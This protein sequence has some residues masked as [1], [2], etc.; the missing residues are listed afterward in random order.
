MRGSAHAGQ[1]GALV[2]IAHFSDCY[3]PRVNGVTTSIEV[4]K[5]ALEAA[6]HEV[7]LFT[8]GY[9]AGNPPE[10]G[11]VRFS[12]F[13][14]HFQ[15]EDRGILPWPPRS[16]KQWLRERVDVVHIHTPFNAGVLG[17]AKA[18]KDRV[19]LI[20][21]HHTLWEE[22]A[23]YLSV[24]PLG[25]ARRVGVALADFYF[26]RSAA[27]VMP[28]EEIARSVAGT[29]VKGPYEVI[30]TGIDVATF[31]GGERER[32]FAELQLSSD[33]PV[34]LY[35]GR[36]GKEKSIDFLLRSFKRYR[37]RQGR[38]VFVV[39]GGGP[40]WEDLKKLAQELQLGDAVRFLGYRPRGE[41]RHYLAAASLF[42][43]ASQTETQGLVLLEAAAAGVPVLAVRARGVSEAVDSGKTGLLLPH[44]D[45]QVFA[46]E[47]L[48]LE[49]LP[50][51]LAA[52]SEA[53]RDWA[54]RFSDREMARRMGDL[55]AS[56]RLP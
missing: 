34:F 35:V 43:F 9:P 14:Q 39:I 16:L 23:H 28:S 22:Y 56:V 42:L 10:Q 33:I 17:W 37:E 46:E 53:S 6:G 41:L 40:G 27:V 15:P 47:L 4:L 19:P 7:L 13:Y 30:P 18:K 44:P 2:R 5:R 12:S 55:Y 45:E 24:L 21:T 31:V 25:M 36:M 3:R 48:R 32:V 52:W 54:E 20:F 49:Q 29:R 8:P 50:E 38:G 11:V 51:Q 1:N 26:R